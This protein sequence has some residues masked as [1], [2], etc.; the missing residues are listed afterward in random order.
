MP[1]D[2]ACPR[3]RIHLVD[4]NPFY[5]NENH[6]S[7]VRHKLDHSGHLLASKV[8]FSSPACHTDI[9]SQSGM[10]TWDNFPH[11]CGS[12]AQFADVHTSWA[13]HRGMSMQAALCH[14]AAADIK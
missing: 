3:L 7:E 14:M 9:P 5:S 10:D 4:G 6:T 11:P 13:V 2:K 1:A 8:H 12:Y